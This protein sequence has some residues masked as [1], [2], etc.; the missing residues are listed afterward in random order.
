MK[1]ILKITSL[2]S[3]ISLGLT[4]AYAGSSATSHVGVEKYGAPAIA[5]FAEKVEAELDAREVNVAIIARTGR[6][7]EDLPDGV[8]YTHVGIAVYEAIRNADNEISYA[9]TVYNLY[10]GAGGRKDRSHLVQDFIFDM[11]AGI[12]EPKIGVIIPS[13]DLQRKMLK[14]MRSPVYNQLHN[15]SYNILANPYND[16]FDNCVSHTLEV[17]VAGMMDTEDPQIVRAKI[18]AHFEAQVM[19]LSLLQEI[20]VGFMKGATLDDQNP[21]KVYTAT[22]GSVNRFLESEGALKE[23]VEIYM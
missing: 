16:S 7:D 14:V 4:N 3:I 6:M 8:D 22:F 20:G 9:Y 17:A 1:S 19:K 12:A 10:Q 2:A 13:D 18:N 5:S 11:C 21:K 15:E 23:F